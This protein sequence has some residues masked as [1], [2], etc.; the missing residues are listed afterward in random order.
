MNPE[1]IIKLQEI[2]NHI[3]EIKFISM[4]VANGYCNHFVNYV[5]KMRNSFPNHTIIVFKMCF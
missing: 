4:D 2:L 5:K 3:N 1:E